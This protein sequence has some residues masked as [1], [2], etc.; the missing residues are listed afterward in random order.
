M[1]GMDKALYNF[2]RRG[3]LP[4]MG[5]R[6]M[7]SGEL[8]IDSVG[9][10]IAINPGKTYFVA[11]FGVVGNDGSSWEKA[12]LTLAAAIAASNT[13]IAASAYGTYARNRIFVL[14]TYTETLVAFPNKCDVIGVGSTDYYDMATLVGNHAPV[15]A[16]NYGTR[17]FNML[18]QGPAVASP[19]I[20]LAGTT[21]GAQFNDCMFLADAVTTRAILSTASPLLK[22]RRCLLEGAYATAYI[23][24]GTGAGYGTEIV[25]N[26]MM[27]AA[28][29]GIVVGSGFTSATGSIIKDNFIQAATIVIDDDAD[30]FWI[31][32]NNLVTALSIATGYATAMDVNAARV[33]GNFLT[34]ANIAGPYPVLDTTT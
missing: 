8:T 21:I 4:L 5:A 3:V 34:A 17:F 13:N 30:L 24:F 7:G 9:R 32:G 33:V 1:G 2:A 23:T 27:D 26:R 15:N 6:L 16:A 10:L 19:I 29:A 31:V 28:V 22:V 25:G 20:T 11:P 18:F 14:G 12:F